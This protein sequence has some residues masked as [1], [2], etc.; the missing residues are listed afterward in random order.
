M[1]M[2]S[3]LRTILNDIAV[4]ALTTLAAMII[5]FRDL[6]THLKLCNVYSFFP[7]FSSIFDISINIHEYVNEIVFI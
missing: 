6:I 4:V 5:C 7:Y 2:C 1:Q 3:V